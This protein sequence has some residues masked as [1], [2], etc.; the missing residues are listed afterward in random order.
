MGYDLELDRKFAEQSDGF[1]VGLGRQLPAKS[2]KQV[3]EEWGQEHGRNPSAQE[4]HDA[5]RAESIAARSAANDPDK[6]P[7]G[8]PKVS[9]NLP[10]K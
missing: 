7:P 8:I 6:A 5:M 10:S 1:V 2:E 9:G 4:L 3:E